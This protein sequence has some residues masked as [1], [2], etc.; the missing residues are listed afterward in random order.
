MTNILCIETSGSH[1]SLALAVGESVYSRDEQ[2]QRTHNEHLLALLDG[3]LQQAQVTPRQLDVVAFGCGP[4][5]FTGVRI[6][7]AAAQ[8]LALASDAP[9]VSVP[10][11]L[12][13]ILAAQLRE[14]ELKGCVC[15][16]RS[17]GQ[18]YY[19]AAYERR[20]R[21]TAS[22][23]PALQWEQS[24]PDQLVDAP[25]AWLASVP[26]AGWRVVGSRPDWWSQSLALDW[27]EG[28][29]PSATACLPWVRQ[30]YGDGYARPAEEALPR[31]IQGDSPWKKQA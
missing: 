19:L 8:A 2:L 30:Q 21:G 5:S 24:Q 6:A 18:A 14:P 31:Y 9:V 20:E 25:P 27:S 11:T 26:V 1:C 17:R 23:A 28:L 16:I 22:E 4:G 29:A 12:A 7:A 10:S 13:W 15:S 3:L